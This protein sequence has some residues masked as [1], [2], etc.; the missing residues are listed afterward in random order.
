MSES[1]LEKW[2]LK[3]VDAVPPRHTL[4]DGDVTEDEWRE[5]A[6]RREKTRQEVADV[7]SRN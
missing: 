3:K 5:E 4:D 7:L 6:V 1:V 2:F